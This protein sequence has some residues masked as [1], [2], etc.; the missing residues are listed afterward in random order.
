MCEGNFPPQLQIDVE[1]DKRTKDTLSTAPTI[2]DVV[3]VCHCRAGP[4][5]GKNQFYLVS[6]GRLQRTTD[7]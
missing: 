1:V 4:R 7:A 5:R 6:Q 2:D 3:E